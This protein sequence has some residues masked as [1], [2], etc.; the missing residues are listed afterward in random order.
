MNILVKRWAVMVFPWYRHAVQRQ[1]K[2]D[3]AW[4]KLRAVVGDAEAE[5]LLPEINRR[6]A[7]Y[8][9]LG[10]GDPHLMALDG[11]LYDAMAGILP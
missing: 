9:N 8:A 2:L 7:Y 10:A 6:A 1:V 11:V 4:C 3:E 5:L